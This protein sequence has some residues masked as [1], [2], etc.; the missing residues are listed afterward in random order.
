MKL[1]AASTLAFAATYS[2][3]TIET[4]IGELVN[5][6]YQHDPDLNTYTFNVA[7]YFQAVYTCT[8]NGFTSEGTVGN[9]NG[10]FDFTEKF[11]YGD[12]S[13]SYEWD[14]SGKTKSHPAVAMLAIPENLWEDNLNQAGKLEVSAE[15]GLKWDVSGA[16]NGAKYEQ[17]IELGLSE[18]TMTRSKYETGINFQR[19]SVISSSID[20][21]YQQF[22]MPAGET[23]VDLSLSAKKICAENAL[24]TSCT[25]KIVVTGDNDG[26]D[27]GNN[28]ARYSV[29]TKKAQFEIKHN[30]NQVFWMALLG[31]DSFEVLSLKYKVNGGKAVLAVQFA[32]PNGF[33]PLVE[34]AQVF[35]APYASFFG[36]IATAEDTVHIVAYFDKVAATFN[37]KLFNV[38]PIIEATKFESDLLK[39]V[40]GMKFQAWAQGMS[41]HVADTIVAFAQDG[42]AAIGD[43]R[44][45]INDLT[46]PVGETKF[47]NWF[48][49]LA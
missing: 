15:N 28:V 18:I 22:F 30:G 13:G 49:T 19:K 34:A 27:F 14:M 47:D 37:N 48:A 31:I 9:G 8:G 25:G 10:V 4:L 39:Q 23:N 41:S 6:V 32:G 33:G 35:G 16:I 29:N 46:G 7:P 17:S 36:N 42:G 26:V 21:F 3:Q 5:K 24:D 38:Y 11:E 40:L 2:A 20:Q 12:I 1:V 44:L 45:Y 43:A